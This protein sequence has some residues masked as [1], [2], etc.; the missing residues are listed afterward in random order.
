MPPA[1]SRRKLII[2]LKAL[3]Y[4]GPFSGSKHQLMKKGQHKFRIP[5]PHRNQEISTD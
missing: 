4:T 5:N 3:V 1:I 2:K